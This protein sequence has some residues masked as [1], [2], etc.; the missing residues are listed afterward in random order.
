MYYFEKNDSQHIKFNFFFGI[1]SAIT[2]IISRISKDFKPSF[3]CVE[4][5]IKY[6][7]LHIAKEESIRI[8]NP[9]VLEPKHRKK[10]QYHIPDAASERA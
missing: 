7:A 2:K 3:F 5:I 10:K 1:N 4:N 6:P 9:F 8:L